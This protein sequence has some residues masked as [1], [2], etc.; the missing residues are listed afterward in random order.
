MR[1]GLKVG[2]VC[3]V[4]RAYRVGLAQPLISA[5]IGELEVPAR[6]SI[7]WRPEHFEDS[8]GADE[9][10]D[11]IVLG[12]RYD[13][14]R[15]PVSGKAFRHCSTY[16]FCSVAEWP[17]TACQVPYQPVDVGLFPIKEGCDSSIMNQHIPGK[18]VVM[19]NPSYNRPAA[20]YLRDQPD[21]LGT[22]VGDKS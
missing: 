13:T 22:S 4:G 14:S 17:D 20:I 9:R 18:N 1:T 6:V 3:R 2:G 16:I 10:N 19:G 8:L 21:R 15:V 7:S 12:R 5:E 11:Q